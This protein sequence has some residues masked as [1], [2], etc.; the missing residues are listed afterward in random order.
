MKKVFVIPILLTYLFAVT[1]VMIHAHYCG[2]NLESLEVYTKSDGCPDGECGDE[3]QKSDP[4]CQDKVIAAKI[5]HDQHNENIYHH[6]FAQQLDIAPAILPYGID[7]SAVATGNNAINTINA[8]NAPPG[9][10]QNI[11]LHKLH[12]R[13]T[14]YG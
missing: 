11:S 3:S 8:P 14:Y 12:C 10:W 7:I 6:S 9:P 1:G 5:T 4:C 2:K 13:F